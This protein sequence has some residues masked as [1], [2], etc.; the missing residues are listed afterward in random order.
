MALGTPLLF[1]TDSM[2]EA[3][4]ESPEVCDHIG[5]QDWFGEALRTLDKVAL[6]HMRAD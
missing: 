4:L 3:S 5:T 6:L 2:W 1:C